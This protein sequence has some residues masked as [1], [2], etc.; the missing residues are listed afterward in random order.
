ME[1]HGGPPRRPSVRNLARMAGVSPS[2]V[3]RAL[4]GKDGVSAATWAR[5]RELAEKTGLLVPSGAGDRIATGFS[6]PE[7][8]AGFKTAFERGREAAVTLFVDTRG[9][10]PASESTRGSLFTEMMDGLSAACRDF[11]ASLHV[12]R[13]E[14][15]ADLA[16]F[17]SRVDAGEA[18]TSGVIW[19]GCEPPARYE[20]WIA[21]LENRGLPLVM[22]GHY[23]AGLPCDAVVGDDVGGA[24]AAARHVA[25]L[26]HRRVAI[27]QQ[28]VPAIVADRTLGYRAGLLESGVAPSEITVAEAQ[29]SFEGGYGAA[30]VLFDGGC[31]AILCGS[32]EIAIGV[33]RRARERNIGVPG[34]VSIV[35]FGDIAA[36]SQVSPAITTVRVDKRAMGYEAVRRLL[37]RARE[38]AHAS[39]RPG[40]LSSGGGGTPIR[41]V[42][43]AELVVR[44]STGTRRC[45]GG[46]WPRATER[47]GAAAWAAGR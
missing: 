41:A 17:L 14:D 39:C 32:D 28:A 22:C 10:S 31:T 19:L 24:L 36:S 40:G 20:S 26:G 13:L 4:S 30:D 27:L 35:G 45:D 42:V 8:G 16:V 9:D 43:P 37:V 29:S 33:L 46:E 6:G 3:S 15:D 34:Q 25:G 21:G 2:T 47:A 5:I 38:K 11:G 1:R 7:A 18:R 12:V 44:E 23:V